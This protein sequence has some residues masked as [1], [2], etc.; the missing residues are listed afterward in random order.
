[1]SGLCNDGWGGGVCRCPEIFLR[2]GRRVG[3][4]SGQA[5]EST[6]AIRIPSARDP[7]I[8]LSAR[9]MMPW[10]HVFPVAEAVS[11]AARALPVRDVEQV[12]RATRCSTV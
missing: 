12:S 8:P 10:A 4:A 5:S 2:S 7:F 1:M 11:A 6:Q 3:T 9:R